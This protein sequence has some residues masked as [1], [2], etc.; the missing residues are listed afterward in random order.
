M[1]KCKKCGLHIKNEDFLKWNFCPHCGDKIKETNFISNC[2]NF[3]RKN[4]IKQNSIVKIVKLIETN[5]WQ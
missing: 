3:K 1:N 5:E 4:V 2:P